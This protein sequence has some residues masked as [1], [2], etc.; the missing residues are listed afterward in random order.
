[1][2]SQEISGI[3]ANWFAPKLA[4][5]LRQGWDVRDLKL[6][7]V[8]S[9]QEL[10][11]MIFSALAWKR[12]HGPIALFADTRSVEFLGERGM[13][14]LY[15]AVH[16]AE[17]DSIDQQR[18]V[19]RLYFS[20][21][22]FVALAASTV[23]VTMLDFDL[24]LRRPLPPVGGQDFVFAHYETLGC[25]YYPPLSEMPNPNGVELEGWDDDGVPACNTAVAAFGSQPH[26]DDF[27]E[28][29]MA[30]MAGNDGESPVHPGARPIFAEQRLCAYTAPRNS[31]TMTP[32]TTSVWDTHRTEWTRG[33]PEEV[34]HHTWHRKQYFTRQSMRDRYCVRLVDELLRTYPE[35]ED[36]LTGDV[37]LAR[38]AEQARTLA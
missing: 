12:F 6:L 35:A 7:P 4:D 13:L 17:I 8:F 18:Y 33:A 32:L 31:V 26:L 22:K 1:V 14:R 37:A 25:E 10:I 27:V 24:F 9:T 28:L 2:V 5:A 34:F 23:P 29:A 16:S 15:D 21:P 30:Y 11:T 3:H 36:L 19:P 38:Y 20:M